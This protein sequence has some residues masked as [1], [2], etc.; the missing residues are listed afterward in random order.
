M[1]RT[2]NTAAHLKALT[3]DTATVA[4]YGVLFGG[5]D[6]EGETFAPDTDYML[7]LAPTKLVF[8]DHTLGDVKHV[9]GKTLSVEPDEYG[10]W[11]EAELN[12]HAAYVDYVVQLVEKG[13]L[14]WSSGSVGHLTRRDGKTI[15][16]WPIVEM[17]LTP[18]P[19]EPRT[20]GVELIKS[21]SATDPAFA[22]LLPETD[23]I[24]GGAE[25]AIEGRCA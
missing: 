25:Q 9:I 6:L 7:D 11:V 2:K 23:Q 12:R 14:G 21:L 4:G 3:D 8:Y 19:A 13:A 20:L 22:L 10:L 17:S 15:K 24:I 1:E 16:T 18:T 5:A